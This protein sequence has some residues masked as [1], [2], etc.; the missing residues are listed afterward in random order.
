MMHRSL[1]RSQ[2]PTRGAVAGRE[3]GGVPVVAFRCLAAATLALASLMA[4]GA[5]FAQG[6]PSGEFGPVA[7]GQTVQGAIAAAGENLVFHE[8]IVQVPAGAGTITIQIDGMGS[9]IDLAINADRQLDDLDDADFVD[10]TEDPN[11]VFTGDIPAG[12]VLYVYVLN[13]LP[14]PANYALSVVSSVGGATPGGRSGPASRGGPSTPGSTPASPPG[15]PMQSGEFGEIGFGQAVQ[16]AIAAAGENL[17]FHEYIV[18]V[19]AGAGTITIQIDG[20]GSDIDLA[21]NADRQLDDLDDAD[22]VDT[23]ED[24]NPVFTG[25]IPAGTVLYVYVLNLLPRPASYALMVS[26]S[27]ASGAGSVGGTPG[28]TPSGGNPLSPADPLVGTFEGD[29]LQVAVQGG[30]GTYSGELVLNGQRF[31]F[32]A[33][34][35]GGNLSGS[36]TSGGQAYAFTATLAGD[37][38]TVVSGGATYRTQRTGRGGG[39]S[40]PL[41]PPGGASA[42][43]SPAPA[44]DPVLAEGPYGT[45]TQDNAYAFFEALVF[46]HEQVG[47]PVTLSDQELTE[48]VSLAAQAYPTLTPDEQAALAMSREIWNRVQ[49]NWQQAAPQDQQEFVIGMLTL[50]YGDQQVQQWFASA[51]GGGGSAGACS[52]IDACFSQYADPETYNDAMNAQ[53]C[54]AA[55]GCSDYDPS[56]NEFTYDDYS[57]DSSTDY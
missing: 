47:Y 46:A 40:N 34:G 5:A 16:G 50:W 32:Q 1:R 22:F 14:R 25:D 54:W 48:Y 12:T 15:S 45:F 19:P 3:R 56:Y 57:Y 27:A 7:I 53:S 41:A 29:G 44:N 6:S 55:A 13:L 28:A 43:G 11:P 35:G 49:A 30:G 38:L 31:P 36:F 42:P 26:S 51:G 39:P 10:T 20:M 52:D 37:T 8:Y 24:P 18:Q 21:I 17:V 2:A 9:D 33:S 23:T 4:T